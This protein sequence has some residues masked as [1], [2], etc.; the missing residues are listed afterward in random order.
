MGRLWYNISNNEANLAG[1][2]FFVAIGSQSN[3]SYCGI[4]PHSDRK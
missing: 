1:N 3:N 4:K 2:Q